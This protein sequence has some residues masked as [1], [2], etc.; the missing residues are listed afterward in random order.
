MQ[1]RSKVSQP[2]E[3]TTISGFRAKRRVRRC[4]CFGN[5]VEAR[6][7]QRRSS[8]KTQ[9]RTALAS[10]VTEELRSAVTLSWSESGESGCR[11]AQQVE[12][13]PLRPVLGP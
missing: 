1:V 12:L 9:W 2:L 11:R 6:T 3:A 8:A 5:P 10:S 13:A 4:A 7:L